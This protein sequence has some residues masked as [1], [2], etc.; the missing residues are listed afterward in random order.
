MEKQPNP[1]LKILMGDLSAKVG[2][3]NTDSDLIIGRHGVGAQIETGEIFTQFYNS[4]DRM[5][6]G[7]IF[8]TRRPPE[9]PRGIPLII[10]LKSDRSHI[11][12]KKVE[13]NL[14]DI[15]VNRGADVASDHHLVVVVLKTKLI[16]FNDQAKSHHANCLV[17]SLMEKNM[18]EG[19]QELGIG[20]LY[21][22]R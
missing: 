14:H 7:T 4:N 18:A 8:C 9:R 16:A 5:T 22:P 21:S 2:S 15:R 19:F 17:H 10:R 11:Y 6:G 12:R 3:Y 20:L 13:A 1:C